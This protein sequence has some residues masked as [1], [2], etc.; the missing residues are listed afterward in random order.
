MG[1]LRAVYAIMFWRK[2]PTMTQ[3][4]SG[5]LDMSK[6]GKKLHGYLDLLSRCYGEHCLQDLQERDVAALVQIHRREH[7]FNPVLTHSTQVDAS[8]TINGTRMLRHHAELTTTDKAS[9]DDSTRT[10]GYV[11]LQAAQFMNSF[12]KTEP[13][14]SA[15]NESKICLTRTISAIE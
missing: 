15:S 3:Q 10:F 12:S 1:E 8:N 13:D 14:M 5:T 7:G 2:T 6:A 9:S 11:C 4:C